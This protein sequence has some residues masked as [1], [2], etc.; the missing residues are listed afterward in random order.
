[1]SALVYLVDDEPFLME[2]LSNYLVKANKSWKV[3]CF[4]EP[5]LLLDAVRQNTPDVVLSDLDMP[6][7]T[8]TVMLEAVRQAA[9]STIRILVSGYA[10]PEGLGDKLFSAQQY[11]AKPFSPA[12]V[13]SIINRSLRA[14]R[15]FH[16]AEIRT[17]VLSLRTLPAIP[18]IYQELLSALE[19]PHTPNSDIVDILTKDTGIAAKLLQMANS[20]LFRHYARRE[21]SIDMMQAVSL[22]GTDRI[23]AAVL[24][25]HIFEAYSEIPDYFMPQ[26]ASPHRWE[27]AELAFHFA[28][29]TGGKEE[30]ARDAYV[31]GLMHD[32]GR[33]VLLDNMGR[34]YRDVCTRALA[35][36]KLLSELEFEYLKVTQ[37]DIVG[38]LVA[39][40]GM[41]ERIASALVFQERPWDAPPDV[42]R[43][44]AVVYLAHYKSH[45][46]HRSEMF[47][48]PPLNR[49]FLESEDL[50]HLLDATEEE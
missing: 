28:K 42:V 4:A 23:K 41:H 47:E 50:L 17:T 34:A 33:L 18:H 27:T 16:N 21:D 37:A 44:A 11:L 10:D 25:H 32:M 1:M 2:L 31:A 46:L 43:T 36:K 19:N 38:F 45:S 30:Q 26:T 35:E 9:P 3:E 39:L 6:E 29:Q 5:E 13:H 15:G 40:W 14:L 8:G 12:D 20:P 48:Q 7:M 49:E 24:S 22:L